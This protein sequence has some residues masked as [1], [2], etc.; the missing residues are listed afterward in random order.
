MKKS[1]SLLFLLAAVTGLQAQKKLP[2]RDTATYRF[3]PEVSYTTVGLSPLQ[4]CQSWFDKCPTFIAPPPYYTNRAYFA[5]T[6]YFNNNAEG[7]VACVGRASD[8]L[9][10]A[11][12]TALTWDWFNEPSLGFRNLGD[13]WSYSETMFL[14]KGTPE[15]GLTL[16]DSVQWDTAAPY[17]ILFP[18]NAQTQVG[19]DSS[20]F[21]YCLA[22]DAYFHEPVMLDSVY[23][24]VSTTR[25]NGMSIFEDS[26]FDAEGNFFDIW[27]WYY[28]NGVPTIY[29]S[30]YELREDLICKTC[31]TTE[32]TTRYVYVYNYQ[33]YNWG[34]N[35]WNV[36]EKK[37]WGPFLAI[38]EEPEDTTAAP[39]E[40][41]VQ[42]SENLQF[43]VRPN[44]TT[45]FINV[46][47]GAEGTYSL[48]VYDDF[49]HCIVGFDFNGPST[50]LDVRALPA[51]H[52]V[53]KVSADGRTG[54]KSFVK[55]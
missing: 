12:L 10:V 17:R 27:M 9:K 43:T 33:T 50:R 1:I 54:V 48:V 2:I 15:T 38:L 51:G 26:I 53:V 34:E 21:L 6:S 32:D 40:S 5:S 55:R 24:I 13:K 22:Y 3:P 16:I 29:V 46:G 14:Y 4:Y 52:Y 8:T 30:F 49:G 39:T 41:I 42:T 31:L 28:Y 19:D 20:M 44:P 18:S 11:G 25:N 36:I 37:Q 7:L 35:M 45:T 47:T 23:T